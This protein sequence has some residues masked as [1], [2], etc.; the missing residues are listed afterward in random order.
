MKPP[1]QIDGADVLEW[2]WS[3]QAFGV[4]ATVGRHGDAIPIH[5]LALCQYAD[6]ATIYRFSC[7]QHWETQQDADYESVAAAKAAL[8]VQ[9]RHVPVRWNPMIES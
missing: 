2:A 8:P 4:V 5:G 9:Y 7:D 6:T 1:R 3:D